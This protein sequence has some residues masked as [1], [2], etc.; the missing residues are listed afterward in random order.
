MD[1]P[2]AMRGVADDSVRS[3][4]ILYVHDFRQEDLLHGKNYFVEPIKRCSRNHL[5][6]KV[7]VNVFTIGTVSDRL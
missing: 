5:R 3:T 4:S 2:L 7:V 1:R 6:K